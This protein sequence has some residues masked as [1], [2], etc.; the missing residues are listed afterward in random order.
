MKYKII[1]KESK[2]DLEREINK[3]IDDGWEPIGGISYSC[4]YGY[5]ENY[6]QAVIKE[7]KNE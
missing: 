4:G 5:G 7:L 1:E 2:I 3:L 6:V